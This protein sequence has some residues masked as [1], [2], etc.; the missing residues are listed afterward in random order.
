MSLL[1]RN[2]FEATHRIHAYFWVSTQQ[3]AGCTGDTLTLLQ[4]PHAQARH[5]WK[6]R[7]PS[8][9]RSS[10]NRAHAVICVSW[11]DILHDFSVVSAETSDNTRLVAAGG[12]DYVW[13]RWES[14]I[15]CKLGCIVL[16][17]QE[18]LHCQCVDL[19]SE[20]LKCVKSGDDP[21]DM[22]REQTISRADLHALHWP[23]IKIIHHTTNR[24]SWR[25]YV[26]TMV[27]IRA[28]QSSSCDND[29]HPCW[30]TSSALLQKEFHQHYK[31]QCNTKAGRHNIKPII[32][33]QIKYP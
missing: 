8:H 31:L 15:L 7:F 19:A 27:H 23:C 18:G 28:H 5:L 29:H 24:H 20:L 13:G 14:E 12:Y 21:A 9:V 33:Y 17:P 10:T 11:L 2:P 25:L 16:T 32:P 4:N 6:T 30:W 26:Y 3:T 22:C 1:A